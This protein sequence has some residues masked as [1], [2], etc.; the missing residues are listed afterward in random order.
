MK[1]HCSIPVSS[2][3]IW[4]ERAPSRQSGMGGV[5]AYRQAGR[6]TL[7]TKLPSLTF[8]LPL[9]AREA[10]PCLP[11]P[12]GVRGGLHIA[13][14]LLF[15]FIAV[16]A[17]MTWR[18]FGSRSQGVSEISSTARF[19]TGQLPISSKFNLQAKGNTLPPNPRLFVLR[20]GNG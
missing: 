6:G 16:F 12:D 3:L 11:R 15:L 13:P 2:S 5:P 8:C 1:T 18:G 7:G 17:R 4:P 9:R 10:M 20:C 14:Q 19:T